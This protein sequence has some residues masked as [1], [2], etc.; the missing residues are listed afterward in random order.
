M[1]TLNETSPAP[2]RGF[3]RV[4]PFYLQIICDDPE[5]EIPMA[6]SLWKSAEN[7]CED[8]GSRCDDT[9][10]LYYSIAGDAV[11]KFCPRHWYECCLG[12]HAP[13][14]LLDMT[15][16]QYATEQREQLES[17]LK[18]WMIV[19]ERISTSAAILSHAGLEDQA[20]KLWEAH[21]YIRSS[22]DSFNPQKNHKP[23]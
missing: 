12:P 7:I 9:Q 17:F 22:L 2:E 16:E 3:L 15:E 6:V 13:Y 8:K 14:R 19:S 1:M 20:G 21:G 23:E 4:L 18:D 10:G 11:T 5:L